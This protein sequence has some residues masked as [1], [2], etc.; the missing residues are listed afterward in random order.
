MSPPPSLAPQ[1][2]ASALKSK[3][4]FRDIVVSTLPKGG[5]AMTIPLHNGP[6]TLRFDLHNRYTLGTPFMAR[7]DPLGSP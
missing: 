2:W 3:R 4:K 7:Q 6:T 5:A 1:T